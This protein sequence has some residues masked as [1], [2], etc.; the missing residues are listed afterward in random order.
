[1]RWVMN[2]TPKPDQSAEF[3]RTAKEIGADEE[4]SE[5]DVLMGRL[6][7]T[8]PDPKTGKGKPVASKARSGVKR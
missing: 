8:P 1:L 5:A 6:A 2:K 4:R 3:I 7:H